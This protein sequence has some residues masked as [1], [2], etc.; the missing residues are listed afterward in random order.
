MSGY[1]DLAMLQELLSILYFNSDEK[2]TSNH[3]WVMM[4]LPNSVVNENL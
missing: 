3:E 1:E 4:A 2:K